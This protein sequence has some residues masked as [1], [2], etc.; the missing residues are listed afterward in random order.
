MIYYTKAI[1]CMSNI[2]IPDK[3][4]KNSDQN[5]YVFDYSFFNNSF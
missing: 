5:T 1:N 2:F 4:E 3:T